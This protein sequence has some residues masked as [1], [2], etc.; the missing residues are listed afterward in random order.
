MKVQRR[1]IPVW[2]MKVLGLQKLSNVFRINYYIAKSWEINVSVIPHVSGEE[3]PPVTETRVIRAFIKRGHRDLLWGFHQGGSIR[4]GEKPNLR[5]LRL[6]FR[7][8]LILSRR[9]LRLGN[10]DC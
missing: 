4:P 7:S 1:V 3:T 9:S 2:Q 6:V 5:I 10:G 8:T